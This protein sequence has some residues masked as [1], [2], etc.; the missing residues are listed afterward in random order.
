MS[1]EL[2]K[3]HMKV[4]ED[5]NKLNDKVQKDGFITPYEQGFKDGLGV[6]LFNINEDIELYR[7]NK[8]GV[9]Y[10]V[11]GVTNQNSARD[12]FPETTVYLD[13]ENLQLWSRPTKEFLDKN[14]KID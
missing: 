13:Y 12:D 11:I 1:I 2:H 3:L 9:A 5:I 7:N 4:F 8:S 6:I 10:R 14:T